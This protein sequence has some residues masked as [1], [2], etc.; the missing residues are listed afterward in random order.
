MSWAKSVGVLHCVPGA[1]KTTILIEFAVKVMQHQGA[2]NIRL[3]ITEPNK[4]MCEELY[5]K[6]GE[7]I[8]SFEK[9]ARIGFDPETEMDHWDSF[10]EERVEIHSFTSESLLQAIDRA[11]ALASDKLLALAV[12]QRFEHKIGVSA[13]RVVC[14]L[15]A[16]RHNYLNQHVYIRESAI[17][18]EA[19]RE[20]KVIVSTASNS[21]RLMAIQNELS[22]HFPNDSRWW[23]AFDEYQKQDWLQPL[24]S[25]RN[26]QL[27]LLIGDPS[28]ALRT[29]GGVARFTATDDVGGVQTHM[30][31]LYDS[32]A[33]IIVIIPMKTKLTLILVPILCSSHV[34][35]YKSKS[36][37]IRVYTDENIN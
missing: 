33:F 10:L 14:E 29:S 8:G 6:I 32:I 27:A 20:V 16:V 13:V 24:A 26:K 11:I 9:I 28:Q 19:A 22:K 31:N 35:Q 36:A 21:T 4:A 12:D 5:T 34:Y 17:K 18:Q 2:Y 15:L 30:V 3:I 37:R 23:C 25:M 7:S 1:G